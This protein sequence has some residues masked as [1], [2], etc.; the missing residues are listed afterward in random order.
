MRRLSATDRWLGK[1]QTRL[2][3]S[4][5]GKS[6]LSGSLSESER[7]K[8][9]G[10]MRVNHAGE[11]AAQGLY[12]GQAAFARNPRNR[13]HLLQAAKEEREH[14][15]MCAARLDE[16]QSAPSLLDPMW[17]AGSFALGA[18]VARLGDA[19][20]L[21]FV[22]ETE[23]QV[24]QHLESHLEQ[25]PP[26]DARSR[27]II[28]K[29]KADEIAHGQAARDRGGIELPKPIRAGMRLTAKLMTGSAYWI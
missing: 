4:A 8:V 11:V 17:H 9:S 27:Q 15:E 12:Q 1:A 20:S 7:R 23:R 24:E 21:G 3:E 18:A 25:L 5:R 10:L 16:L 2:A 22:S 19:V 29:M 28:E 13:E 6:E 26:E 14:L